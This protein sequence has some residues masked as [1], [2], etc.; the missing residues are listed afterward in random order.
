MEK[1]KTA[2]PEL[3]PIPVVG[4][5]VMVGIDLIGPMR[6]SKAGNRYVL[7]LTDY[8][9]KWPEALPIPHKDAESVAKCLASLFYRYVRL[10]L[11]N[12]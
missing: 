6:E 5:W 12:G 2:A 9:S 7:T 4:S 10:S 11:F 8:F 1:I 3:Q